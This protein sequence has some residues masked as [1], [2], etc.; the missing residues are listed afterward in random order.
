[1]AMSFASNPRYVPRGVRYNH[2]VHDHT[3][4]CDAVHGWLQLKN[5]QP[6]NQ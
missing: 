4:A 3:P 5:H 6:R 2:A 1:M